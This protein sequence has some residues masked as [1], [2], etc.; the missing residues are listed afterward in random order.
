MLDPAAQPSESRRY[1]ILD[2]IG[3]GG[4]GRV[5]RAR[6]EGPGSF[7]KDVALKV[8]RSDGPLPAEVVERFRDEARILGLVRDR[9]I[10]RVD[11][12]T[13]IAGQ[14]AVVMEFVDGASASRLARLGTFP[15]GVVMEIATE[16]ARA[17]HK[18]YGHPGLDGQP[19]CLIHRDVKPANIQITPS[20]EVKL[21][22]FGIAHA[23]FHDQEGLGNP[24]GGTRGYIAPE[25]T[26]GVE[27]PE[28]DVYSLGAVITRL[29]TGAL[30]GDDEEPWTVGSPEPVL[31]GDPLTCLLAYAHRMRAPRPADRPSAKAVQRDLAGMR[32]AAEGEALRDWAERVIPAASRLTADEMVGHVLAETPIPLPSLDEESGGYSDRQ[33]RQGVSA[34]LL[35][36]MLVALGV[37]LA[38][39]FLLSMAQGP[40]S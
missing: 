28:G 27:G 10:V 26:R 18:I 9:A 24:G 23:E 2:L 6:L 40:I 14:W 39:L 20:G 30:P 12:P 38:S 34:Y 1:R 31:V 19:L 3:K 7:V 29:A 35:G 36:I 37:A 17:L 4:F 32:K 8:L 33:L 15:P 5:Y 16:I 25:R 22:D 13:L 21:L 11:P